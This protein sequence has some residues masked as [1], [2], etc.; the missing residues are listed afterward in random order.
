MNVLWILLASAIFIVLTAAVPREFLSH[1]VFR[2]PAV[3]VLL[4]TLILPVQGQVRARNGQPQVDVTIPIN[5]ESV[6]ALDV[7]PDVPSADS[8]GQNLRS[9]TYFARIGLSDGAEMLVSPTVLQYSQFCKVEVFLSGTILFH[10]PASTVYQNSDTKRVLQFC[11]ATFTLPGYRSAAGVYEG[12]VI[13]LNRLGLNEG[14]SVSITILTAPKQAK[15]AYSRGELA[16]ARQQWDRAIAEFRKTIQIYPKHAVAWSELGRALEATGKVEE[17]EQAYRQ[18]FLAD[19]V[20]LKPY[21]QLAGLAAKQ[22]RWED[23]L[24]ATE[25]ALKLNPVEFPG[26]YLCDAM[27]SMNLGNLPR[28]EQSARKSIEI[29]ERREFPQAY[30]VLGTVLLQRNDRLGA[31]AAYRNF[32]RIAPTTW[33]A[34]QIKRWIASLEGA[35]KPN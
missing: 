27:A 2:S 25:P 10:V 6:P 14:S 24:A 32:V 23:V 35:Q 33:E 34:T 12:Q 18:A 16:I 9:K 31:I 21:F 28:A 19:P 17:A 1:R 5:Q 15:K 26:I 22:L 8:S 4:L 3:S 30:M 29:D 11:P 13:V 7:P 20:Y